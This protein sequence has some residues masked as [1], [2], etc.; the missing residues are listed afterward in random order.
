MDII[1]YPLL[2]IDIYNK[3]KT[4][5]KLALIISFYE[6]YYSIFFKLKNHSQNQFL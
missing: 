2:Q 4:F 5:F 6:N 1:K 3:K